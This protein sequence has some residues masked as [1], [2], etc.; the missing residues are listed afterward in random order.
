MRVRALDRNAPSMALVTAVESPLLDAPHQHAEMRSFADHG[1]AP[2]GSPGVA[3]V[4]GHSA[5]QPLL[6]LCSRRANTLTRRGVC[7]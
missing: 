1:H 5:Q 4:S 7:S 3:I 2:R 6:D